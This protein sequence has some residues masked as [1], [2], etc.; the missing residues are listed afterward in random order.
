[1]ATDVEETY[2]PQARYQQRGFVT[3]EELD[4]AIPP[5]APTAPIHGYEQ[6]GLP[7]NVQRTY[8]RVQAV[9]NIHR[10]NLA[11]R[12]TP[13]SAPRH[14]DHGQATNTT[15][16]PAA[17]GLSSG[18]LQVSGLWDK[19]PIKMSLDPEA[20]GEVFYQEFCKWASRRNRNGD[21]ERTKMTLWLKANKNARD[22]EAYELS[23]KEGEL[24][25]FWEE[26]IDWIQDNKNPK[27]PHLYATVQLES[28]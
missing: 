13:I 25:D 16:S 20:S 27:A 23:L 28:G 2:S 10:M 3:M 11:E 12:S 19:T 22:D 4:P 5:R 8:D 15:M 26:A 24:E 18:Q 21:I 9:Q 17:Q 7:N 1:M 14:V 6:S